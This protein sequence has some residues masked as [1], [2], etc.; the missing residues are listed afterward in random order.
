MPFITNPTPIMIKKIKE[1]EDM[2]RRDNERF[3]SVTIKR[4]KNH[5]EELKKNS[6]EEVKAMAKS[7]F[8]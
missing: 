7:L 6:P 4:I 3:E 1:V 8:D 2:V 5:E